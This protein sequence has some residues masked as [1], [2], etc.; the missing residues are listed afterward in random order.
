MENLDEKVMDELFGELDEENKDK[1]EKKDE[2]NDLSSD[3]KSKKSDEKMDQADLSIL[4]DSEG[5]LLGKDEIERKLKEK[6]ENALKEEAINNVKN[7]DIDTLKEK[8][9]IMDIQEP[10]MSGSTSGM[11]NVKIRYI[12]CN[13]IGTIIYKENNGVKTITINYRQLNSIFQ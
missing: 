6:Q 3:K 7:I 12:L 5:N 4:E 8:L 9:G 10:F 11:D 1:K 13:L 2:D